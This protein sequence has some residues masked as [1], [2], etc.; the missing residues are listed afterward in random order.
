MDKNTIIGLLLI[1]AI[2]IGFNWLNRPT[3]EQLAEMKRMQDSIALVENTQ[4][5][6]M[7]QEIATLNRASDLTGKDS[8]RI[9]G[10][11]GVFAPL[12]AGN[13]EFTTL[14]NGVLKL[15]LTNKGGRIYSAELNDYRSHDSLPLTLFKGADADYSFTFETRSGQKINTNELYFSPIQGKDRI[16]MRASVGTDQYID[17]VYSVTP[18]NY[19]VD[20]AIETKNLSSVLAPNA[21]SLEMYWYEKLKQQEKGRKFEQRYANINYKLK[22]DDAVETLS[23][24]ANDSKQVEGKAHWIGYT[25]QFFS[26]IWISEQGFSSVSLKSAVLDK[27]V[28]Y[29]KEY[30][31]VSE[32]NFDPTGAEA[33]KLSIY[34]GPNHYPTLRSFDKDRYTEDQLHLDRVIP[35]GWGIFRWINKW[36]VIPVFNFLDNFI[37]SYGIIILLLTLFIK[38]ILF[39]FTYKSYKST[40]KMRVL[41]PQVE[42]INKKYPGQ[43]NAMERQRATMELYSRVGASPMGGCLPM[44]LQMPILFAMFSFFP[45]SIE[46][47]QKSFLWATDL[48]SYDAVITWSEQI[49]LISTY[50]GNHLS[51]FCL[52]MTITNIVY[53]KF[54]MDQTNTGQEQMPGMKAMMYV[55]PLMFLFIFNEYAAGLSYYYFISTLITIIQ[56]LAFRKFVNEEKILAQL[57]ANAKKP[58][59]KSGFMARLEE[60]QRQQQQAMRDKQQKGNK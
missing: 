41:R 22:G 57:H 21:R 9:A 47:R 10:Q 16:T 3:P 17:F 30:E 32:V 27:S 59:K 24:S 7:K 5:K 18:D 43:E 38:M 45:A 20:F 55:M 53:T 46:L 39:P 60:A 50:F 31:G 2:L 36:L 56:T 48:S 29:L 54:N 1:G 40:A 28:D 35:L 15:T 34:L 4:Q 14:D 6:E 49:P 37:G 19:M 52:L 58:K 13:E 11:F 51:L 33:T 23:E 12:T 26:T 8:S 42:E 25:D 44:L